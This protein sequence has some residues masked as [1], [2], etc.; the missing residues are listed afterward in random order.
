MSVSIPRL[1]FALALA[2]L[3][4]CSSPRHASRPTA[5][6]TSFTYTA[7]MVSG[8]AF[9][10]LNAK[11]D[12]MI[13]P[14][15]KTSDDTYACETQGEGVHSLR[16]SPAGDWFY[17]WSWVEMRAEPVDARVLERRK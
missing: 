16:R 17:S 6:A 9:L 5:Q 2:C 15:A 13:G 10:V 7:K 12:Q 14:F 11:P 3:L 8:Q 4:S 1:F